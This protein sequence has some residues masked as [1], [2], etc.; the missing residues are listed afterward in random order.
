MATLLC[1][2]VAPI[3]LGQGSPLAGPLIQEAEEPLAAKGDGFT[4]TQKELNEVYIRYSMGLAAAGR[5]VPSSEVKKV[6]TEMLEQLILRKI[7]LLKA[8]PEDLRLGKE[9]AKEEKER[10]LKRAGEESRLRRQVMLEGWPSYEDYLKN[11]EEVCICAVYME[12]HI[13]VE[14]EPEEVREFYE[15][16][17]RLFDAEEMFMGGFILFSKADNLSGRELNT[18]DW[19]AKKE[20]AAQVLKKARDGEDFDALMKEHSDDIG[21]RNR[22]ATIVFLRGQLGGA[23]DQAAFALRDGELSRLIETPEGIYLVKVVKHNEAGLIALSEVE[24][25]IEEQL[26]AEKRREKLTE[27]SKELKKEFKVELIK[28]P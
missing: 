20:L 11:M 7:F 17:R 10:L 24:K 12:R 18:E 25:K 22:G 16:N 13:K 9:K 23:F 21:T 26:K 28:V 3:A 27:L 2:G 8:E 15:S 14:V 19:A 6:E 1:G 4:V 5:S